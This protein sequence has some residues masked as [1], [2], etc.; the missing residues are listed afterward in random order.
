MSDI[1][2][3]RVWQ[4]SVK[5]AEF[6]A[7]PDCIF[8]GMYGGAAYGGKS[9]VLGLL[10]IVRKFYEHPRFKGLLLR[11][12]YPELD[13]EI[14]PRMMEYYK[15]VGAT[16]NDTKKSWKFPSGAIIF[17]GH[18]E[19]EEDKRKYDTSEFNYIGWDEVTSFT[20]SQYLY[21]IGSRC[22]SSIDG[23]PAFTRAATNPGNI[24][25]DFFKTRFKVEDVPAGTLIKDRLSGNLRIFIKALPKD[26]SQ[27]PPDKLQAYLNSLEILPEHEKQ[28]KKY[29]SWSSFEGQVFGEFRPTRLPNEPEN[30]LHV[31]TTFPVPKHW[32]IILS[33]DWGFS[34]YFYAMWGAVAPSGKVFIFQE[35]AEKG[36]L[37][38]E[39]GADVCRMSRGFNIVDV[40]IDPATKQKSGEELNK[41]E[42]IQNALHSENLDNLLRTADNDRVG[43][44]TLVQEYIRWRPLPTLEESNSGEFDYEYAQYLLRWNGIEVYNDYVA[45]FVPPEP[46]TNLPKLQIFDTCQVLIKAIPRCIYNQAEGKKEDVKEFSGDDPYDDLRYFL[47][48]VARWKVDSIRADNQVAAESVVLE[49]FEQTKDYNELARNM[50]RLEM[51]NVKVIPMRRYHA[52]KSTSVYSQ[53]SN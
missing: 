43:G 25:H 41:F 15:S 31:V 46:E 22:R 7:L 33:M 40:V 20:E 14:I 3:S 50:E 36:K 32:P 18:L 49:K 47:K 24:S 27:V 37:T 51:R 39:A 45:S 34:A 48:A 52:R 23:L 13:R 26:N 19:H 17:A 44:K 8:E 30:A 6:L 28:A 38:T 5:Q 4:P 11:R 35:Y 9:E 2:Q 1:T 53:H 21:I 42:Q 10:P 12:T 29:G 16:W